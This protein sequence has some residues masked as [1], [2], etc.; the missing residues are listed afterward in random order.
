MGRGWFLAGHPN[1]L[2]FDMSHSHSYIMYGDRSQGH[3]HALLTPQSPLTS[4]YLQTSPLPFPTVPCVSEKN[5]ESSIFLCL[6]PAGWKS[7]SFPRPLQS[8]WVE[9]ALL[10]KESPAPLS[11]PGA[12]VCV[13]PGPALSVHLELQPPFAAASIISA[14]GSHFSLTAQH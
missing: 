7:S 5:T 14:L 13:L 9:L 1:R 4:Q 12:A 6:V 2:R 3:F 8:P 10:S 11:A